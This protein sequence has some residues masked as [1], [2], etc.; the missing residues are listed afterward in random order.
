MTRSE[1]R[2]Y[3]KNLS[4]NLDQAFADTFD[5]INTQTQKRRDIAMRSLMWISRARRPLR[6]EELCQA[7]ATS[8]GD[9]EVDQDNLINPKMII[10]CCFGLVV[11]DEQTNTTR[12]VHSALQDYLQRPSRSIPAN[13]NEE[14]YITNILLTWLCFD[15]LDH[16]GHLK[17]SSPH[18]RKSTKM[19]CAYTSFDRYAAE[20]W[21][22]HAGQA[23]TDDIKD[24][25]LAFLKNLTKVNR[26]RRRL[27]FYKIQ[28]HT[29]EDLRIKDRK[30]TGLH[31]IAG[32]GLCQ[33]IAI[34]LD[35]GVS[36]DVVDHYGNTALHDAAEKG[37]A[38]AVAFLI[39]RGADPN[40]TNFNNLLPLDLAVSG[41]YSEA[42]M[43][44]LLSGAKVETRGLNGWSPLHKAA[45]NG[46][47]ETTR[48]L[49]D[50]GASV[51]TASARGLIPLHRAAG[52]GHVEIMKLLVDSGSPSD[53][54]TIDGWTPIH[55]ASVAGQDE[56]VR[57]LLNINDGDI[58][59]ANEGGQ[60]ALHLACK[61]GHSQVVS[62]LLEYGAN[63][64]VKDSR[65]A[66]PLYIA[67][68]RGFMDVVEALLNQSQDCVDA[69]LTLKHKG[70]QTPA[71]GALSWAQWDVYALL[72]KR[73]KS[74]NP[75][76]LQTEHLPQMEDIKRL[77][78]LSAGP[79]SD[80]HTEHSFSS[81]KKYLDPYSELSTLDSS[82]HVALLLNDE[83]SVRQILLEKDIDI[84]SRGVGGRQPIHCASMVDNSNL[85][86]LCLESGA[87][88]RSPLTNGQ[89]ALHRTARIGSP[90]TISILLAYGADIEAQDYWGWRPLHKAATN[91]SLATVESLLHRGADTEART[92]DGW[93]VSVCAR[94][95]GRDDVVELLVS[96]R[97]KREPYLAF[98]KIE[99]LNV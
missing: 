18:S 68:K 62:V 10:E 61:S 37:Q 84:N 3:I 43:E 90:E 32:A 97:E 77:G 20:H 40:V 41:S 47:T 12:L 52:K 63:P 1:V 64:L 55:G 27:T 14:S 79:D 69:Q 58:D 57:F 54:S 36:I 15:D 80:L 72:T 49:L 19:S 50:S 2:G 16:P 67:S 5:R 92:G 56:A 74:T 35:D 73:G 83:D 45:D 99:D 95:A 66:I 22:S 9:A 71:Q 53:T 89:T 25:A 6:L 38:A 31:I 86:R 91:G 33:L 17:D 78:S 24:L 96:A 85:I 7:L 46:D 60:T 29:Y 70:N 88:A 44:L 82:L 65:G 51:H 81:L 23:S 59:K 76:A 94:R 30:H 8:N 26:A 75:A 21:S 48:L 87:D 34:L 13:F 4:S 39:K 93:S 98:P 42:V 28:S 11:T